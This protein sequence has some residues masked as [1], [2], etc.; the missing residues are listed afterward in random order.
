MTTAVRLIVSRW[1]GQATL[2][3]SE[4]T[5]RT[6]SSGLPRPRRP[7]APDS[8]I[9]RG[10]GALVVAAEP[11]PRPPLP[12]PTVL[13]R[14]ACSRLDPVRALLDC[15]LLDWATAGILSLRP[16]VQHRTQ[17]RPACAEFYHAG[18]PRPPAYGEALAR[19][20]MLTKP[21]CPTISCSGRTA[22]PCRCQLRMST[23][24]VSIW[25]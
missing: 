10:A 2:R 16:D 14:R 11:R 24:L 3:S 15:V 25:T 9:G 12:A 17:R 6:K 23:S 1:L 20:A 19:R 22:R 18:R 8:G 5:S 13:P 7:P 4:R 21:V